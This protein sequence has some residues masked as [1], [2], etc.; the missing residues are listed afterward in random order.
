MVAVAVPV[1]MMVAA[2]MM[3]AVPTAAGA[4]I[5]A[6]AAG[7]AERGRRQQHERTSAWNMDTHDLSPHRPLPWRAG[8]WGEA[9]TTPQCRQMFLKPPRL[10]GLPT[11]VGAQMPD[12]RA[13]KPES[14][15]ARRS[16]ERLNHDTHRLRRS[17]LGENS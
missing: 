3:A 16:P 2:A 1:A 14:F 5:V 17:R 13:A 12:S 15:E 10:D 9:G 4:A 11:D 6:E 8:L 7:Q